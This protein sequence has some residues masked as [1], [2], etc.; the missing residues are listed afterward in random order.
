MI[1]KRGIKKIVLRVASWVF[2]FKWAGGVLAKWFVS[3]AKSIQKW[4]YHTDIMQPNAE[5]RIFSFSWNSNLGRYRNRPTWLYLNTGGG[6]SFYNSLMIES[7]STSLTSIYLGT[8]RKIFS[9]VSC[10]GLSGLI[11]QKNKLRNRSFINFS[12]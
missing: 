8:R 7:L 2:H 11:K 12:T 5:I 3:L 6:D 10:N 9:S 4:I 1:N